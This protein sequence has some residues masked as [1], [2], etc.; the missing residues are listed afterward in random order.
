V[1]R[2]IEREEKRD[3][4]RREERERER[5]EVCVREIAERASLNTLHMHK[6]QENRQD[7]LLFESQ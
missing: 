7:L 4:K 2:E 3:R 5:R 6:E 1:R